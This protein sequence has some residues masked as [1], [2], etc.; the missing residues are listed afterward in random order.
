M[1]K[2]YKIENI[3]VGDFFCGRYCTEIFLILEI[4]IEKNTAKVFKSSNYTT[5]PKYEYI[6]FTDLS[7]KQIVEVSGWKHYSLV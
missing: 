7:I 1:T 2:K 4:D 6:T 3:E 5:F